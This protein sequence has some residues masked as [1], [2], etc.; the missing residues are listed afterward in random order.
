MYKVGYIHKKALIKKYLELYPRKNV[1]REWDVLKLKYP[2]ID[3]LLPKGLT[4]EDLLTTGFENL[5]EVYNNFNAYIKT[6][7][8]EKKRIDFKNELKK[9]FNYDSAQKKISKFFTDNFKVYSCHYCDAVDISSYVDQKGNKINQLE[10]EHVLDKGECPLVALSLFNFVPSCHHCNHTLK[11][12]N[13]IGGTT[14]NAKLLSPTI[15]SYDYLHKAHFVVKPKTGIKNLVFDYKHEDKYYID[16]DYTDNLYK[17]VSDTFNLKERYNQDP[18]LGEAF[19]FMKKVVENPPAQLRDIA[20]TTH[21]SYEEL[22]E[23]A[24]E[25]KYKRKHHHLYMKM[26]KDFLTYPNINY[27]VR[28]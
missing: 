27:N 20:R 21:K 28:F 17:Y 26:F 4:P 1:Q 16:I 8:D 11:G 3:T 13:L 12:T 18:I 6:I 5:L 22:V 15:K 23:D 25:M 14:A 9:I 24:F 19:S 2:I 10:I 7:S